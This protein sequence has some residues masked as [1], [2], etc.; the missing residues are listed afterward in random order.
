MKRDMDLVRSLLLRIEEMGEEAEKSGERVGLTF[1][2]E[3]HHEGLEDYTPSRIL[4]H[5]HLLQKAGFVEGSELLSSGSTVNQ[6][7]IDG[8]TWEG[9]EFLDDVRDPELWRKTKAGAKQAGVASIGLLWQFAK[10]YAKLEAKK[11]LPG[12]DLG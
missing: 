1:D 2:V 7:D 8:I 3:G 5:L 10:G 6:F 12:L 11:F 9:H 4:Y